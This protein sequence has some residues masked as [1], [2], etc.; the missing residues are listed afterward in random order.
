MVG[1]SLMQTAPALATPT[2][3]W[4]TAGEVLRLQ[5]GGDWRLAAPR[6][7]DPHL[8]P[9]F[10]REAAKWTGP[11]RLE[12]SFDEGLS[13][14]SRLVAQIFAL[15]EAA[16]AQGWETDRAAWPDSICKL[17]A[18]AQASNRATPPAPETF[19]WLGRFGRW[20]LGQWGGVQE[21]LAFM[22]EA[23]AS[24]GRLC[25][26]RARL[27]M[28]DFLLVLQDTSVMAL[29]IVSLIS[30]LVGLII[31][32]LGAVVLRQFAAE[33]AVSYLVGYGMLREMGA[34]MTGVIMAGFTGAAFAAQIG[35]MKVNE[36]IDALSTF[37]INPMD[38]I[39]LPRLLALSIMMPLLTIYANLVGIFG[40]WLV[41]TM[42][43]RVPHGVFLTGMDEVVSEKDVLLG[44]FKALVFGILVATAGCH[45]GL[46][47]GA[48]ADAVGQAA[49]KAVVTGIT[50]IIFA[51]ALIDWAA[52]EM[53]V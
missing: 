29:P 50:L 42:M 27:R 36:E 1:L 48:G 14:D 51:N 5:V 28:R 30:F 41:A 19:D 45:R 53:G 25:T 43:M 9:A 10:L 2:A 18:L 52:A 32:F 21:N 40:G 22:G 15:V 17:L 23:S 20:S 16:E 12:L 35:S 24:L 49:T 4:Q 34:V 3:T 6:P 33:F 39:V 8:A 44:V 7:A 31:A 46:Q 37:G 11:K 13:F 47:A 38:F 26:G